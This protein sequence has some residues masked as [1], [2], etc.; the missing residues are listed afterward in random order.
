MKRHRIKYRVVLTEHAQDRWRERIGRRP[1][2][3]EELLLALLFSYL[4][5]GLP[6]RRGRVNLPLDAAAWRLP[7]DMVAVMDLP[8]L[9]GLWRVVTFKPREAE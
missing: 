9:T 7:V 8:D 1:G 2:D 6:V 5:L 4:R 3:L